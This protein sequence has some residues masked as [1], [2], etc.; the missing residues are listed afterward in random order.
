MNSTC[1]ENPCPRE[2]N[3]PLTCSAPVQKAV[4]AAVTRMNFRFD[5]QLTPSVDVA[6]VDG[7]WSDWSEW[8]PCTTS[9]GGGFRTRYRFCDN[10]LPD[11]GGEDCVGPGMQNFSCNFVD[12]P[13][14][15]W[16]GFL[17][18][19]LSE[20]T[21]VQL[22]SLFSEP[23]VKKLPPGTAEAPGAVGLGTM[24]LVILGIVVG[25]IF[26][27]DLTSL[28]RT[29]RYARRNLRD[30]KSRFDKKPVGAAGVVVGRAAAGGRAYRSSLTSHSRC[31][32]E[33]AHTHTQKQPLLKCHR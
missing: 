14:I 25:L 15:I 6:A 21:N 19:A 33:H 4:F 18:L 27:L 11:G 17:S 28:P 30:F 20:K 10:P 1:N 8:A 7:Q 5:L 9:C 16:S 32:L 22:Q 12:C 29:I 23:R 26:F 2:F 24:V 31:A 3:D 13:S